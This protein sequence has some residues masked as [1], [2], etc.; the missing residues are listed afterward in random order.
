MAFTRSALTTL[1]WRPATVSLS[2]TPSTLSHWSARGVGRSSGQRTGRPTGTAST[3]QQRTRRRARWGSSPGMGSTKPLI[4][5]E[6]P[7]WRLGSGSLRSRRTQ[8]VRLRWAGGSTKLRPGSS[9]RLACRLAARSAKEGLGEGQHRQGCADAQPC[10]PA[11]ARPVVVPPAAPDL[12]GGHQQE[13]DP[14]GP[15][16]GM[17]HGPQQQIKASAQGALQERD[18]PKGQG[19]GL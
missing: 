3:R 18:A 13:Q 19:Q 7:A 11:P 5:T 4:R 6:F 10:G 8:S 14:A 2:I 15:D 12:H 1:R 16:E 9:S 17:K